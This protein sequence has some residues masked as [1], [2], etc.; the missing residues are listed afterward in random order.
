MW[1]NYLKIAWRNLKRNKA[2]AFINTMGLTLGI[3]CAIIIF[4]VVSYHL[5]FDN[6]HKNKDRIFR[7]TT[8]FHQETVSYSTGAPA[9]LGKAIRNECTFADKVARIVDPHKVLISLPREKEIKKFKET[10]GFA[11][12]EPVF[13]DIF[14]FPLLL[15]DKKTMLSQPNEALVT[16]KIARKYFGSVSNAMGKTI[17]YENKVDFT[18]KGVLKDPPPNSDV[19]QQ[20]FVSYHN[21]KEFRGDLA[22]D[23]SWDGVYSG[24]KCYVLLKPSIT[25]AQVS[26]ALSG[27]IKKYYN[28]KDQL[29][30]KFQ[31]QP[32][33]DIHFN[34]DLGGYADK[35]YLWALSL[36]GLFLIITACVNF[37]NLATA[38]ALNRSKE[39]GIRKVLGSVRSQLFWQF[40]AET[41]LITIAATITAC[42][43]AQL[44]I[45][46]LNRLLDSDM[47][48]HLF[49][50][51]QVPLFLVALTVLVVFL[52]GSYPGL[53]LARFQPVLS[54]KGKLSQK[55]IGGFSLRRVLVV[56]QFTISQL[57]IIGAIVIAS[58]M[59]YSKTADMGFNKEAT[60]L[61]SMPTQD[62]AKMSTLRAKLATVPGIEGISFCLAPPASNSNNTTGVRYDNR[63][64]QEPWYVNMKNADDQYLSTFG[65]KLAAG[66]NIFP[67]D[68]MR[69]FLVNETFVRKLNLRSPQDVIGK[70]ISVYGKTF[71]VVGVVKDFYLHSFHEEIEAVCITPS[72]WNYIN[73]AVR[74]NGHNMR[75]SL[76]AMEKVWNEIYPEFVYEYQFVDDSIAEF[77][78]VDTIMLR[79]VELFACIAIFIGCL[80]LYGL[81]SFMAVRRTKEIGVRK[82]LGA[83]VQHIL[84]LFGKEFSRLLL[85]A[86]AI[87]APLAWWTM[88]LY[89]QDFK[90]RIQIGAGIFVLA[91]LCT[92]V[93]AALTVGYR[94]IRSA[95]V[96]PVKSLRAE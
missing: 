50:K 39:I 23:S 71:P 77:Y 28:S 6:F 41:A 12:T 65:L 2:Y 11:F 16:E 27:I 60:V 46:Y 90:Y 59:H 68:T 1:K 47:Q 74:L 88:S 89:L 55:H 21:L 19:K 26:Q 36:I 69:E 86:F 84:W 48:L 14:D 10:D 61:V 4:T 15:G 34:A 80:G 96:N 87:A 43:L 9:P 42:C 51:P 37:I 63:A 35:K 44:A 32:L 64:E 56:T 24:T 33:S 70:Q 57:L 22:G 67:S 83:G 31:P 81:V 17:R 5:S 93:I 8:E 94:S 54:L 53:V 38:Q 7:I 82:V 76:S 18:V 30:W 3:A 72:Y 40:I 66:R 25:T 52:S 45:P 20:I 13:F 95:L 79:M 92:F 73:C 29:V 75:S 49:N 58:Q 91:I 78:E 85:I 62:Q